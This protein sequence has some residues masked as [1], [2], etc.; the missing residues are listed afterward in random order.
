MSCHVPF[1]CAYASSRPKRKSCS[2]RTALI[3]AWGSCAQTSAIAGPL[4]ATSWTHCALSWT[5]LVIDLVSDHRLARGDVYETR[6]GVCRLGPSMA[7]LLANWAPGLRP[8]LDSNA[9]ELAL[10]LLGHHVGPPG[11]RRAPDVAGKG[12]KRR[13]GSRTL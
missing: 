1:Y 5:A 3:P 6:A 13:G 12:T 10:I 7:H 4:R 8:L 9:R 11:R 2:R